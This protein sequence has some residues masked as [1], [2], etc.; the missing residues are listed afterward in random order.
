[1]LML[2]ISRSYFEKQRYLVYLLL[3]L[4]WAQIHFYLLWKWVKV[5]P[6]GLSWLS[7]GP[8]LRSW[9]QGLGI[10]PHIGLPAQRGVW[11][12][13]SLSHSPRLCFLFLIK[14]KILK[15]KRRKENSWGLPPLGNWEALQK[16]VPTP[17]P[18]LRWC[19]A[20]SHQRWN[21]CLL[22]HALQ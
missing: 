7:I 11:F 19:M 5:A 20:C 22:S 1:M 4:H 3:V 12:C 17:P 16:M 6:G 9:F 8:P 14:T 10:E 21:M 15:K 13:L 18:E 2:L